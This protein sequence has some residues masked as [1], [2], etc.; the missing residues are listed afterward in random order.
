M[1]RGELQEPPW[2]ADESVTGGFLYETTIHMLDMLRWLLGEVEQVQGY[3]ARSVYGQIDDVALLLRFRS[4]VVVTLCSSAHATWLFP[5]ERI[6]LY[7]PHSLLMTEEIERLTM[8]A[9]PR[10]TVNMTDVSALG[11]LDKAGYADENR[12]FLD[13]IEG[14]RP[15]EPDAE[16]AYRAVELVEA[17]YRAVTSGAPVN[18]P[19]APDLWRR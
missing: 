6:E 3:G 4:G 7:G 15:V 13:A 10:A 19:L 9:G 11:R 14:I 12:R 17:C 1:N 8:T 5:T 18:L 16:D 2:T